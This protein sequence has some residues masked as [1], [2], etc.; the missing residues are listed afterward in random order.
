MNF[1]PAKEMPLFLHGEC[2]LTVPNPYVHLGKITLVALQEFC[3][4]SPDSRVLD[5][6]CGAGRMAAAFVGYLTSGE[7]EALT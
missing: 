6:G 4:L 1:S 7:Y 3:E 2:A 5:V